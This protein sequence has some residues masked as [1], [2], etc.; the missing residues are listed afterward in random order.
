[1]GALDSVPDDQLEDRLFAYGGY[2]PICNSA[3]LPG[4]SVPL[5]W[6]ATGLPIG[7]QFMAAFGGEATLFRLA[8][9]LERARPWV[10]RLLAHPCS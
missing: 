4:M 5:H 3:G 10:P 1:T 7:V 9:Q 8:G 2:T 6:N